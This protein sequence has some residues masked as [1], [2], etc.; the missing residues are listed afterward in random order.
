MLSFIIINQINYTSITFQQAISVIIDWY[1]ATSTHINARNFT[2][3]I[4]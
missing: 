4:N 1:L 2:Y 3:N